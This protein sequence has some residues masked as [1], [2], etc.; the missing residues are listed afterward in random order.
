VAA[1]VVVGKIGCVPCTRRDMLD[2]LNV[3][4]EN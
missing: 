3:L 2:Y 1:G 4:T